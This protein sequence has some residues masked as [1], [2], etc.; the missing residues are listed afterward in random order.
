MFQ[1]G[2][3]RQDTTCKQDR[4]AIVS[5]PALP[6]DGLSVPIRPFAHPNSDELLELSRLIIL[7]DVPVISRL[8]DG[9]IIFILYLMPSVGFPRWDFISTTCNIFDASK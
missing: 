5:D 9:R 1:P 8:E 2:P 4:I 7:Y 3:H 6:L